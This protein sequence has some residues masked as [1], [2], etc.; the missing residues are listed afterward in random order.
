MKRKEFLRLLGSGMLVP[1]V[2]FLPKQENKNNDDSQACLFI[3]DENG[4]YWHDG[5]GLYSYR[6]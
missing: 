4:Y 1:L 6:T 3:T 5:V 2:V